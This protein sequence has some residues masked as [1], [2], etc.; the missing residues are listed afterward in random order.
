MFLRQVSKNQV[1]IYSILKSQTSKTS[2]NL[3]I[4]C[5]P[6]AGELKFILF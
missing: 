3:I 1:A 6:I 5:M 4:V 2:P